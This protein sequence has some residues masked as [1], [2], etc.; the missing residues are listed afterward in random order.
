MGNFSSYAIV[1]KTYY[2]LV[3][4][5]ESPNTFESELQPEEVLDSRLFLWN[6]RLKTNSLKDCGT[7]GIWGVEGQGMK[8]GIRG[9]LTFSIRTRRFFSKINWKQ[10]KGKAI[11]WKIQ[12]EEGCGRVWIC[13]DLKNMCVTRLFLFILFNF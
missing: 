12:S 10:S 13:H 7:L 2:F 6:D 5:M 1:S 11:S 8:N 3:L 4:L 9:S